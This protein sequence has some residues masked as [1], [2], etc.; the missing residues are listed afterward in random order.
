VAGKLFGVLG[1]HGINVRAVAQGSSELNISLVVAA[2]DEARTL[3]AIHDAFF[4]SGERTVDIYLA[5]VGGVGSALLKQLEDWSSRSSAYQPLRLRLAGVAVSAGARLSAAGMAPA[6]AEALARQEDPARVSLEAMVEAVCRDRGRDRVFVDCTAG[7]DVPL[8]Y[9][10]VLSSGAAVVTANKLRLAASMDDWR[11]VIHAP[12]GRFYHETTVGAALPIIGTLKDLI[13]TGDRIHRIEGVL[14]GTL[15]LLF[16]ELVK[17]TTFSEVVRRAGELGYTEPDP[18]EDLG[19]RDVARKLLILARLAGR[20]IE[21]EELAVEGLLPAEW[22]AL[23]VDEFRERVPELDAEFARRVEEARG[24]GRRIVYLAT[25]DADG[26]RVGPREVDSTHPA[27][28]EGTD[29]M[30]AFTT[31]RYPGTPLVVRGPGA[32]P[33]LTASGVFGDILRAV[34]EGE[35]S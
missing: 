1:R 21:P 2:A 27:V 34:S 3:R 4:V 18:R 25:L 12:G 10:S 28:G 22:S 23:S 8:H 24:R 16:D 6:E 5:G 26:A 33:A 32:G 19:G 14:S 35:A 11:T 17:G 13:A 31:D 29:N 7:R 20:E 30:V 15:A 9:E